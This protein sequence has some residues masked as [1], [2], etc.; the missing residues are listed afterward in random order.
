[1][2]VGIIGAGQLGR[3]LALAGYP[4][5]LEPL[6]LD[7]TNDTP[8]AQV[9]KSLIGDIADP[10]KVLELAAQVDVVTFD[11]ENVPSSTLERLPADKVRPCA[12]ALEVS[13]DRVHE[14]TLFR[15]LDIPSAEFVAVDSRADLDRAIARIRFPAVLK[16]RRLGYDGKGQAVLRTPADVEAAWERLGG[17]PLILEA[18]VAFDREVSIL[19]VR[20]ARGDIVYYPL[21]ENAHSGGILRYC[22]APYRNRPL[23]R[24][25]ERHMR[26]VL[27]H[28]EYVGVLAIEFF[29][30]RGRLIAN[31]MAPRVHNTGH[32]TIEGAATSQFENHLRAIC[33][34][35]LGATHARGH[36]AMINFIGRLP[37]M[38]FAL[39]EPDLHFHDYGK[40]ARPG[41]KL[42]HCTLMA[43]TAAR[44]DARLAALIRKFRRQGA[45]L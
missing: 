24:L 34:L 21:A 6:F 15:L 38:A 33:G 30:V 18:F 25:A 32:W 14:K 41:R 28:F 9:G 11:W 42:G 39:A 45:E 16:T 7:R 23:Q 20:G 3:M 17:S 35:E 4:L 37:S 12:R 40:S 31:E 27:R 44:R 13:Q 36:A 26:N 22:R 29:V 43:S 10:A 8:G 1:M 5:G 19:G 2:K